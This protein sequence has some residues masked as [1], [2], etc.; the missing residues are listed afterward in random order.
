MPE[1]DDGM[2]Q[3]KKFQQAKQGFAVEG[4]EAVRRAVADRRIALGHE[5]A[6]LIPLKRAGEL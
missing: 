1:G 4:E 6:D 3:G 2:E 5:Q